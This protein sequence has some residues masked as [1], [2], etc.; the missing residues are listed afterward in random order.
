M[1][2]KNTYIKHY[3][4][5]NIVLHELIGLRAKVLKSSDEYKK[6]MSGLVINETKNTLVLRTS[7]GVKT[8][9]KLQSVFKFSVSGKAFVVRGKEINFRP[10]ERTE[11]ALKYYISR[12]R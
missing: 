2:Y 5:K 7:S 11:K 12:V 6:G 1:S 8:I 9:P 10:H 3:D 4:N